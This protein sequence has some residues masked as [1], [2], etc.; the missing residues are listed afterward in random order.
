MTKQRTE[1]TQGELPWQRKPPP[2]TFTTHWTIYER[3]RDYPDGYVLRA[4]HLV[5]GSAIVQDHM[6][7]ASTDV[8]VLR[9]LIAPLQLHRMPRDE[10]DPPQ[11]LETWI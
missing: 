5:G 3:P 10:S 8:E 9:K 7:W 2:G 4:H 1:P 11:I 6:A